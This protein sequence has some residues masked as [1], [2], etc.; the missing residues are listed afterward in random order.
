MNSAPELPLE[1][2]R[3]Q[4]LREYEILDTPA[5]KAFDDLTVLAA[6]LCGMPMACV[7]LV[8][9]RRV[10]LK[11]R[12]GIALREV[13]R[14]LAFCALALDQAGVLVVA[15][16]SQDPR[17]RGNPLVQGPEGVR[18]VTA[19]PLVNPEG[20]AVGTLSVMDR[21]PGGLTAGQEKA[22]R[23][24]ADQVVVQLELRRHLRALEREVDR[25]QRTED[26]LREAEG[27]Y[28]GI[29]ENVVEG[30]FQTTAR[31]QY[32]TA[33]AMLARIYGYDS[34]DE[35]M[36]AVR[37]IRQ[38]LY[39]DPAR[40]EEFA[41]RIERDGVVSR[42]ESQVRRKDGEIIW[43]SENA[44][45]VR[46]AAGQ[47]L[48]YEGT[49]EDIT[50]RKRTEETLRLSEM[51]FR[52]VWES[53]A[54]G[55]RLTDA[56]GDVLGVNPSYCRLVGRPASE[57]EGRPFT[58][59]YG[60]GEDRAHMLATYRQ[61]FAAREIRARFE[62]Q[63]RFADGKVADV[64]VSTSYMELGGGEA[65]LLSVFHDVSERRRTEDAL[66]K[67]ELL[68]HSLVE[69]LPQNIFR[70]DREGRFT[71]ANQRFCQ[72]L[73]HALEEIVG[74]TDADFYPA[75][76]AAKYARDDQRVMATG[77]ALEV[78]EAHQ[79]PAG[80]KLYVHVVKTPLSGPDGE[81]MGVQGIFWDVT[82]QKEM[83]QQIAYERDLLRMLL[84][85]VPDRIYF[86]DLDSR[87]L[88]VSAAMARQ[89]GFEDPSRA[90]GLTDFEIFTETHAR[91][92]FEDEQAIIRT[93]RPILDK[94]EE[95]TWRDGRVVW[96]LTSK[97]PLRDAEGRTIGTFGISRDITVLKEA[98]QELAKARDAALE[99]ARLKSE[100]LANMSHEIRTPMN[101][102]I[103]MAGL[104]L[105]TELSREQREF[106][107][108]IR[109]SA[110]ALLTIINDILDL[111][112]I[113]A[114]KLSVEVVDFDL[115]DTVE[116]TIE[117]LAER[118]DARHLELGCL[119]QAEVPRFLCGDP[120]RI[121]QVL[122]N[123][124]GNAIKFTE[125]GEVVVQVSRVGQGEGRAVLRFEVADTGVGIP[126]EAQSRLFQAFTQVDGSYTRRHGGTGLGLAISRQLVELMGG[127]IGFTS[128]VD[129][130]S[131]F[132][133]TVDVGLQPAGRHPP[134][135]SAVSLEAVQALVVDDNATNRR[136]LLHQLGSWGVRAVD[137]PGGPAAL[138]AIRR[139]AACREPFA[140]VILDMQMPDMDGLTLARRIK[141]DPLIAGVRL[142][143]LTS[144]GVR[145][146][147]ESWR[148]AGIAA[149]LIKPVKQSR[150]H[151]ALVNVLRGGESVRGPGSAQ[152]V[153][154]S[155]LP[156]VNPSQVRILMAEDNAVNQ[157]VA[158]RQLRKLGYAAEAV[159][160]G[161][162]ALDAVRRIPYDIV[163]MDCQM[164]E[165][166]GYEA[167]RRIRQWEAE[168]ALN[169]L[170]EEPLYIIAMTANALEGD[171]ERC[172]AAGMNDYITKPVQLPELQFALQRAGSHL[173]PPPPP[174]EAP[175]GGVS[176]VDL[177]VLRGIRELREP[178]EPDPLVDLIDLYLQDTP[179][180]VAK[181]QAAL[182]ASDGG[183]LASA[184][185]SLKGSSSNLGA[186]Q[187][188]NLCMQV[189]KLAKAGQMADAEGLFAALTDEFARVCAVLQA[190]R[191]RGLAGG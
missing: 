88:R 178:G 133:F 174:A 115:R 191:A 92:A 25:H 9:G 2:Q 51:R 155:T 61:R 140:V 85:N 19:V 121:R 148:A 163:L 5:E 87:F 127:E 134:A 54:D 103:G 111:S 168:G 150:L 159:G 170:N 146:D 67:S 37:D 144:L 93:G 117:L 41:R 179:A 104:L 24:L 50:E 166:D 125:Q 172:L 141:A 53:S 1:E 106:G 62:R 20:V 4:L 11:S 81:V 122:T 138:E 16:A 45:S 158:L 130:G 29:V 152:E 76:L 184:A 185:H 147:S 153:A 84:E 80:G 34:P 8:D 160:N 145:F 188:A 49:V 38:Q 60:E 68:F 143:M 23:I 31:G 95:E 113:E 177:T 108:T 32:L 75:E 90:V 176:T 181:M 82:A 6:E 79:T 28:R 72:A 66:R 12:V 18:F 190:E 135:P 129:G 189:E 30:I 10:W 112:K 114:G 120:G 132:W 59:V 118:A 105:D 91:P 161:L 119:I 137:A 98:E 126:E 21:R 187:L 183:A 123:L 44:R 173:R 33:N 40:R 14:E 86:K 102:I 13:P 73:G 43:I 128:R 162:E 52:L 109:N 77:E 63:I 17:F 71:F 36:S 65:L 136:I 182:A 89:M 96:V 131:T 139:A 55:M 35:L 149:Y 100:F 124:V 47:V 94:L 3:L 39:A 167:V 107:E 78:T 46:D 27:K 101:A 42:F 7:G 169:P 164:P 64:E 57:L 74:R 15:D 165:M 151:D 97:L 157:K 56:E 22:L 110:D 142:I 175:A 26:L 180:R 116:S 83:E 154:P 156:V 58:E 99:T 186:R 171:R 48:Y 70:K 69:C